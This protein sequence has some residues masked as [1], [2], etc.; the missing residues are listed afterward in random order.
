VYVGGSAQDSR[1]QV[2]ECAQK[3]N[4]PAELHDVLQGPPAGL[5]VVPGPLFRHGDQGGSCGR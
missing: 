3:V 5:P 4:G 1:A 2:Q